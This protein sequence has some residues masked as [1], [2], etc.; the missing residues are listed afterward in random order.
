MAETNI[1]GYL[2][3]I[4]TILVVGVAL[5]TLMLKGQQG[6]N[7]R[8]DGIA[9]RLVEVEKGQARLEGYLAGLQSQ[10]SQVSGQV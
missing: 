3:I 7:Q 2:G 6:T 4:A 8:I 5:A 1:L 10:S 9:N